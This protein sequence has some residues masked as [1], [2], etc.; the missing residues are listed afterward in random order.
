[1]VH[2]VGVY[3]LYVDHHAHHTS[4]GWGGRLRKRF[5]NM[6]SE[7]FTG[8]WSELQ[9]PCCPSKQG[10]LPEN[11]L[12]DLLLY[13]PPQTVVAVVHHGDHH[14]FWWFDLHQNESHRDHIQ[15]CIGWFSHT[16][17]Q[18]RS[19]LRARYLTRRD[20]GRT[21]NTATEINPRYWL[22]TEMGNITCKTI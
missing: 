16:V 8:S 7:S 13:L 21:R 17:S 10:E 4:T 15:H 3:L 20:W 1:M 11:M 5:C 22:E 12:Q 19:L 6:F 9:L 2:A 14:H 18:P